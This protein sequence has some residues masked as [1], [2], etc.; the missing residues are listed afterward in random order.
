MN[1]GSMPSIDWGTLAARK[2]G[3]LVPGSGLC[4]G[5]KWP[6]PRTLRLSNHFYPQLCIFSTG[7][8]R[9]VKVNSLFTLQCF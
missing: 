6:L 8:A 4:S 5:R 1:C 7:K 3:G 9:F 2:T